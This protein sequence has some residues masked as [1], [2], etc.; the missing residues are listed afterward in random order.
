MSRR[1]KR[2]KDWEKEENERDG[3]RKNRERKTEERVEDKDRRNGGIQRERREE[4]KVR[5]SP[6][7][8]DMLFWSFRNISEQLNQQ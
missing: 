7:P 3:G 1:E 5:V 4:H 8:P 6:E 2:W